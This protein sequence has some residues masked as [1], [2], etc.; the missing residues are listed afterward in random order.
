MIRIRYFIQMLIWGTLLIGLTIGLIGLFSSASRSPT[1][2]GSPP[3]TSQAVDT[4]ATP[5]LTLV[6]TAAPTLAPTSTLA[7]TL[8]PTVRGYGGYPVTDT[9]PG[10][11]TILSKGEVIVVPNPVLS[12][13]SEWKIYKDPFYTY[14]VAYPPEW[15]LTAP[16]PDAIEQAYAAG[17]K[18]VL[19]LGIGISSVDSSKGVGTEPR[20]L[21]PQDSLGIDIT[22]DD[23]PI[24]PGESLKEWMTRPIERVW[25][26]AITSIEEV[27]FK[28]L[29]ALIVHHRSIAPGEENLTL[30]NIYIAAKDGRVFRIFAGPDPED[31]IYPDTFKQILDSFTILEQ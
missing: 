21:N 1:T 24:K 5:I 28:G 25:P 20:V 13:P 23:Y 15:F 31:T 6:P 22:V 27:D 2:A 30:L 29:P 19:G 14:T 4:P 26:G 12:L 8:E 7:P 11:I 3:I 10:G 18:Q 17:A 16:P 9:T